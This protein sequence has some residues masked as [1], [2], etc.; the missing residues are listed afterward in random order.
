MMNGAWAVVNSEIL[1]PGSNA[2][3]RFP[4]RMQTHGNHEREELI[5]DRVGNVRAVNA[6]TP[7]AEER[8]P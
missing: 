1:Q 7:P 3:K 5:R 2:H 6:R 8:L 4:Q